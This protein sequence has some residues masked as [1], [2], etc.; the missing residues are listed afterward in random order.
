LEITEVRVERLQEITE[1]DAVSEG[2]RIHENPDCQIGCGRYMY[3]AV[4][5]DHS[6]WELDAKNA[7]KNLWESINGSGS[8]AVNPWVWALTFKRVKP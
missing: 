2:L 8:W 4:P 6:L 5:G 3:T 1:E 7:Y